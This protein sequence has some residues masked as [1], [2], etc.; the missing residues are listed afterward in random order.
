M[1]RRNLE[2]Y[3]ADGNRIQESQSPTDLSSVQA[4]GSILSVRSG[5]RV[6]GERAE[7]INGGEVGRILGLFQHPTIPG[8]HKAALRIRN[9]C[10]HT[11]DQTQGR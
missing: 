7:E 4:F 1:V 6:N 11:V 2:F 5:T 3:G 9:R 8:L 10:G